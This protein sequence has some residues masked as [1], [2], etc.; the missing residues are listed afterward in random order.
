MTLEF[1]TVYSPGPAFVAG[2]KLEEQDGFAGQVGW[3]KE[4]QSARRMRLIGVPAQNPDTVVVVWY[5]E[6]FDAAHALAA[7][8]PFVA[9]G[10]LT[11]RTAPGGVS[12]CAPRTN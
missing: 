9:A 6:S 5:A 10:L 1:T 2:R 4:Q 3:W 8:T 7:A 12:R 11:V